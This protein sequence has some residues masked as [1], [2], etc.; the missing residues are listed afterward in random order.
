MNGVLNLID[1]L[2]LDRFQIEFDE[3][4][5]LQKPKENMVLLPSNV[6]YETKLINKTLTLDLQQKLSPNTTYSLYL[7]G[8][9]KD[10]TE[11]NDSLIQLVFSTGPFLD[12]NIVDFQLKDAFTN[13]IQS[14]FNDWIVRITLSRA[15]SNIP[16]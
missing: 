14:L 6:S 9:V 8:A 13:E 2:E 15:T 3:F 7:N 11:G 10:L 12:S 16:I 4:V 5:V 1:A